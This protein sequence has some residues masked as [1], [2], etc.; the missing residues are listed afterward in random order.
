MALS[1]L[2]SVVFLFFFVLFFFLSKCNT[3]PASILYKSTAGRYRPVSYPDGPITAHYRFIKNAYWGEVGFSSFSRFLIAVFIA[4]L[5]VGQNGWQP[6]WPKLI[7]IE[8]S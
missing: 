6:K 2:Y 4:F 1:Q 8:L 7:H 3:A 5:K